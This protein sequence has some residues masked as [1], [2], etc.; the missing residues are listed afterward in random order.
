MLHFTSFKKADLSSREIGIFYRARATLT[1]VKK[2]C[3]PRLGGFETFAQRAI[4]DIR[5]F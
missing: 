1:E 5:N 3:D 2:F 4:A